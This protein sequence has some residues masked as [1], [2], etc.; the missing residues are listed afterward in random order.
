M[1]PW[2][3]LLILRNQEV[4]RMPS[5]ASISTTLYKCRRLQEQVGRN[6]AIFPLIDPLD[7]FDVLN[8]K[9]DL[10]DTQVRFED[11]FREKVRGEGKNGTRS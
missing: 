9:G 7:T 11:Y 5:I 8:P 10:R 2:E 6:A 1:L 4:Y 3:N